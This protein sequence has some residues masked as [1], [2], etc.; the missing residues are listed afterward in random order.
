MFQK[1]TTWRSTCHQLAVKSLLIS[2]ALLYLASRWAALWHQHTCFMESNKQH[3][4]KSSIGKK[5]PIYKQS[6]FI[7]IATRK[8]VEN[9]W[10][11]GRHQWPEEEVERPSARK[12]VHKRRISVHKVFN[13]VCMG[14]CNTPFNN[15]GQASCQEDVELD[16]CGKH[17]QTLNV[18]RAQTQSIR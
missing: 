2:K 13:P 10:K 6:T 17:A 1:L 12:R 3:V 14:K 9:I 18:Q 16:D 5:G 11:L 15:E 7:P 4:G 8:K